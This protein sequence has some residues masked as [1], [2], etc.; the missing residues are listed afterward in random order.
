MKRA[1]LFGFFWLSTIVSIEM[2]IAVALHK[3]DPAVHRLDPTVAV[4]LSVIPGLVAVVFYLLAKRSKPNRSSGDAVGGWLLGFVSGFVA[5]SVF[6]I[7]LDI[8][9]PGF[10]Q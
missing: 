5:F 7:A 4:I 6:G 3:L 8:I 10:S 2:W 9:Y 1:L